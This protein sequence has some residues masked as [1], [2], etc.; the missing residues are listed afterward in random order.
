MKVIGYK[1][2]P[3][4]RLANWL[5]MRL[6]KGSEEVFKNSTDP[7][8]IRILEQDRRVYQNFLSNYV[9]EEQLKAA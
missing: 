9:T 4:E 7:Q 2:T 3:E 1:D 5:S 6:L 8:Y